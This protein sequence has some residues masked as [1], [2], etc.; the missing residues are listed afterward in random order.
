MNVRIRVALAVV[1]GVSCQQDRQAPAGLAG[2]ERDSAGIRIIENPKPP[3]GSRVPWRIGPEPTVS[4]G[5]LEGEE[6]YMLHRVF[7]A[8]RLSDGRIVVANYGF[9]EVRV[10]DAAGTHLA[11]A[12]GTGEGPGEFRSLWRVAPWPGDSILAWD[13]KR[14]FSVFGPRGN[15]GR[16]FVARSDENP[17]ERR[18]LPFVDARSDGTIVYRLV[19]GGRFDRHRHLGWRGGALG[20]AGCASRRGDHRCAWEPR[21]HGAY[22][23]R[24]HP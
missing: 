2:F 23:G 11:S 15:Y 19:R 21:P 24:L 1:C 14:R 7:D 18:S 6:P 13:F 3:E 17:R 16:S 22:A 4:I 9:S 5:E 8:A 20:V 12:G 10:F